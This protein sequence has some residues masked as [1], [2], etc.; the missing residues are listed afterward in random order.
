MTSD[1][2]VRQVEPHRDLL[3]GQASCGQ[4][5]DLPLLCRQARA[6]LVGGPR[7]ALT[8]GPQFAVQTGCVPPKARD[9]AMAVITTTATARMAMTPPMTMTGGTL[10]L[11][12]PGNALG[13][14]TR[15][16]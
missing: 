14:A 9:S 16:P 12:T 6:G 15:Y 2:S 5:G 10:T 3:V 7:R 8:C 11:P 1:G 4:Q 13:C